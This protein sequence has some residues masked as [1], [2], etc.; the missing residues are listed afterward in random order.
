MTNIVT[1]G[2]PP[3]SLAERGGSDT[4]APM[5]IRATI[6]QDLKKAMLEKNELARDTL[7]IAKSELLLKEVELGRDLTDEET[8]AILQKSVKGRRDAIEQF[9]AGGRNDLVEKEEKELVILQAYLPKQAGEAETRAAIE[10]LANELGATSKKDLG[11]VM[12]ELKVRVPN[13]DGKAASAWVGEIL[14]AR[15]AKG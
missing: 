5:T 9:K 4:L 8:I 14:S 10:A 15:E 13:L 7:R 6:D 11:R 2:V 12:K 3:A 1:R